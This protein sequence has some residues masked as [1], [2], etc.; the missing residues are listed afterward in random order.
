VRKLIVRPAEEAGNG[1]KPQAADATILSFDTEAPAG[2]VLSQ[3]IG[4]LASRADLSI[5][6][7]ADS[8]MLGDA[9][10]TTAAEEFTDGRIAIEISDERGC[11]EIR[12]GPL[13]SGG[14]ERLLKEMELPGPLAGSLRGLAS[15]IRTEPAGED[16]EALVIRVDDPH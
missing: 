16:A 2:E 4:M 8:Q 9:V 14:A 11:L 7:L 3:V 13:N 12:V 5:D 6:R 1:D 10:S 15:D